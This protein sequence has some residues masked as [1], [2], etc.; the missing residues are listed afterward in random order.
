MAE[1]LPC[2]IL[3]VADQIDPLV[4]S[5]A[6]KERYGKVDLVLCAGDL[7]LDYLDFIVSSLNRPLLFVFGNHHLEAYRHYRG[8]RGGARPWDTR[9][10][11]AGLTH[12]GSA[13]RREGPLLIA[14][15]GGSRRYNNGENQYAETRMFFEICKLVPA[16]ILNRIFRGR[17]LDILLTHAPPRGIGDREDPCHRGFTCFL[18][19]MKLFKPRYLVHGHIHLYDLADARSSRFEKTTVI[20]AYGH[21]LLGPLSRRGRGL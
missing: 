8:M 2:T 14:G 7:P 16:L 12:I 4:Y 3:C 1:E 20:N 9:E 21:I 19:F 18:W 17:F 13:V 6:I 5:S 15:L 10:G 11:S